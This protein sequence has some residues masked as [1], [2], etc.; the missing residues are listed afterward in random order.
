[1]TRGSVLEQF[2]RPTGWDERVPDPAGRSLEERVRD[3]LS[4]RRSRRLGQCPACG[5]SVGFDD[6][7]ARVHGF[8][9]HR[10]CVAPE[11]VAAPDRRRRPEALSRQRERN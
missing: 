8:V 4:L 10:R 1:M 5:S 3:E 6:D 9:F 2:G 7:F 11:A